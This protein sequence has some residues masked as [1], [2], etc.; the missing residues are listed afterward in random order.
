MNLIRN[1]IEILL[2]CPLLKWYFV[3][4]F[5][6]FVSLLESSIFLDLFSL[7]VFIIYVRQFLLRQLWVHAVHNSGAE[8]VSAHH[9]PP[10]SNANYIPFPIWH[11]LDFSG[12]QMHVENCSVTLFLS[13]SLSASFPQLSPS[14]PSSMIVGGRTKTSSREASFQVK[15]TLPQNRGA[16]TPPWRSEFVRRCGWPES[17]MFKQRGGKKWCDTYFEADR[18]HPSYFWGTFN[19]QNWPWSSRERGSDEMDPSIFFLVGMN[20][21]KPREKGIFIFLRQP[22]FTGSE[23]QKCLFAVR[24]TGS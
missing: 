1:L 20:R 6:L 23:L 9:L 18:T 14:H 8:N 7:G 16:F 12:A 10:T 5:S 22:G 3:A 24:A 17:S 19:L 11:P 21:W 4:P 15:Q 2:F 13:L